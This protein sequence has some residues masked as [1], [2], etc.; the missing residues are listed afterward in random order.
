MKRVGIILSLLLLLSEA[1]GATR[2]KDL[3]YIQGVRP[4]ELI[5]Y[6]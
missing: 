3:A 2:I 5:G 6:G 1:F 4:N